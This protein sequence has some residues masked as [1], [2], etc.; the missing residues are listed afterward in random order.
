MLSIKRQIF[1][2]ANFDF[3][4]TT[5]RHFAITSSSLTGRSIKKQFLLQLT[6]RISQGAHANQITVL[7]NQIRAQWP[8]LWKQK[9]LYPIRSL[10][11]TDQHM[12]C[13]PSCITFKCETKSKTVLP[14][15]FG[16]VYMCRTFIHV[17]KVKSLIKFSLF[18]FSTH[19]SEHMHP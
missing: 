17:K 19:G 16:S 12:S 11:I 3:L 5:E 4:G 8:M 14:Y 9:S 15:K 10:A 6:S 1:N 18:I 13:R 2:D 7:T